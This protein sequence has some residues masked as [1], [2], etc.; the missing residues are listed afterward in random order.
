MDN[1]FRIVHREDCEWFKDKEEEGGR[2]TF[3]IRVYT[4]IQTRYTVH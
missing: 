3:L 2:D 1:G 4:P